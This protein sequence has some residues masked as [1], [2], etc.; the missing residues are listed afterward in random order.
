[1][2]WRPA[3]LIFPGLAVSIACEIL[4]FLSFA[5]TKLD[6][7]LAVVMALALVIGQ[8]LLLDGAVRTGNA[9]RWFM[10]VLAVALMVLSIWFTAVYFESRF[11]SESMQE[12]TGSDSYRTVTALIA[13]KQSSID[14]LKVQADK[15]EADGNDWIAGQYRLR[16]SEIESELAPLVT[17]LT[18]LPATST[19]SATIAGNALQEWRWALWLIIAS[20]I[21]LIPMAGVLLLR[22]ERSTRSVTHEYAKSVTDGYAKPLR[23]KGSVTAEPVSAPVATSEP[24]SV[25]DETQAVLQHLSNNKHWSPSVR[26]VR[27]LLG[28]SQARASDVLNDLI[29]MGAVTKNDRGHYVRTARSK[30]HV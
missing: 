3:L 8:L 23:D 26:S 13:S 18:T 16:A 2:T 29:K 10:G 7:A 6:Q 25:T 20:L 28:V 15:A 14:S 1:M 9:S 11:S 4:L 17:Q 21:D 30:D 12:R 22:H 24:P 5:E 19:S 27:S